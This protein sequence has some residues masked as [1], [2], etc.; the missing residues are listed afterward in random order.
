M[1]D[2]RNWVGKQALLRKSRENILYNAFYSPGQDPWQCSTGNCTFSRA[3]G[4]IGV[5]STCQDASSHVS[6]TST[7]SNPNSSYAS[8]HPTS[9]ADCPTNSSFIVE[10][11]FT[12]GENIK[13]GTKMTISS[14]GR[15][16]TILLADA[17][18]EL[19]TEGQR[20]PSSSLLFGFLVG[21]TASSNGRTDWTTSDNSTCDSNEL[22]GSWGCQGFGAITC[23]LQPCV[24]IYNATIAGGFLKEHLIESLV[25]TAWGRV[26]NKNRRRSYLALLNTHYSTEIQTL[27]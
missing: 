11:N 12:A 17:D 2:S 26:Y 8:H 4:T 24:H 9:I 6:I 13:L 7:C 20:N 10:S 21:A 15:P 23:F 19:R 1:D 16:D 22:E 3:Y 25:D 14:S 27:L 5:C 18:S